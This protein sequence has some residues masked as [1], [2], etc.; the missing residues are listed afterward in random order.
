VPAK[1]A[2]QTLRQFSFICVVNVTG[3]NLKVFY[4]VLC[5]LLFVKVDLLVARSILASAI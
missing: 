2:V 4:T 1:H 3:F 5:S